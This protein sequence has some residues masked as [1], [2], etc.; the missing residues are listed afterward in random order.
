M[1]IFSTDPGTKHFAAAFTEISDSGKVRVVATGMIH[2]T[3]QDLTKDVCK[4]QDLFRSEI[5]QLFRKY[6][7]PDACCFERFQSRGNGGTL[8]ECV[9]IML[10]MLIADTNKFNPRI[11]TAATWKNRINMHLKSIGYSL[12]SMYSDNKLHSKKSIK[13]IHELDAALIGMYRLYDVMNYSHFAGFEE[14]VQDYVSRFLS[15][16]NL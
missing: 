1:L 10:G 9:N 13:Q 7:K 3:I 12:D 2:N 14:Q 6:G 5:R 15:S 11:I 8:I 16:P 4:Q